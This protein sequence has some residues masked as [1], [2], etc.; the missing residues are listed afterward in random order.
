MAVVGESV[1]F[2]AANSQQGSAEITGNLVHVA[3]QD[4]REIGVH[5]RGVAPGDELHQRRGGV[6]R[7]VTVARGASALLT[8]PTS[9][10]RMSI[11]DET[12][13]DAVLVSPTEV[14]INAKLVGL[15]SL[16]VWDERGQASLFN[17][18]VTTDV[19]ALERQLNE[20][21]PGNELELSMGLGGS[22]VV[23]GEVGVTKRGKQIA[24]SI[25][26]RH[27]VAKI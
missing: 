11:A 18:E 10:A 22:V 7:V 17:I 4:R 5:D 25:F 1:T 19:A 2:S 8:L 16:V 14:L 3:A 23:S 6:A 9:M 24:I 26:C 13:A 21:F 27:I 12:I 15:T 20:L